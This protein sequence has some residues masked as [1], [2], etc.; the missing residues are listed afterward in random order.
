MNEL[1]WQSQFVQALGWT[2]IEFVPQGVLIGLAYAAL[3]L[4][5]RDASAQVRLFA[6]QLSLLA[7]A[8]APLCTLAGHLMAGSTTAV[9]AVGDVAM[10]VSALIR[11]SA[12]VAA[13]QAAPWLQPL[14]A[15]WAAGVLVLGMRAMIQWLGL[16]WVK[17]NARPMDAQWQARLRVLCQRMGVSGGVR[18]VE[19]AW[20]EVPLVIGWLKPVIVIPMGLCLRMP[21]EQLELVIVHELAHL[22][23]FDHVVNLLQVVLETVL[24]YHPVVHWIS[25]CVREDR[26][27]C[28]DDLV[29]RSGGDRRTYARALLALEE[30]R[31]PPT[32]L[33]LAASGGVLLQR[34]ERVVLDTPQAGRPPLALL[35]AVAM[36]FV[37]L[38]QWLLPDDSRAAFPRR[39]LELAMTP[40]LWQVP[41]ASLPAGAVADIVSAPA[42]LSLDFSAPA[43]ALPA[44][45]TE[46]AGT[47]V[48]DMDAAGAVGL[49][50][51]WRVAPA[52]PA[53]DAAAL[54][55]AAPAAMTH[56]APAD[57]LPDP[58]E[59]IETAPGARPTLIS[60]AQPKYPAHALATGR[61]GHVVA[62][63]LVGADGSV[64]G[65]A[66]ESGEADDAFADSVRRA[67]SRWRF[68]ATGR[69]IMIRQEF[70]FR[71]DDVD[72]GPDAERCVRQI[73]SRLCRRAP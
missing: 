30:A 4:G 32:R 49:P 21:A 41:R 2:L 64:S 45:G 42:R 48:A 37:V 10:P 34:V 19:S 24:F 29:T 1:W 44:S 62:S 7:L 57:A 61:E 39:A 71:V 13:A 47:D 20:A 27:Q 66:I 28:C 22:R 18:L 15:A 70:D 51:S 68:A 60:G 63:F 72:A 5:W 12:P 6:G 36:A 11:E 25:R 65:L 35:L 23:R 69:E 52:A 31:V 67:V 46:G 58:S 59:S 14:V 43:V 33:A 9:G 3:R 8:L 55:T 17:R 54:A 50:E 38:V 26:E 53:A 73:G 40:V 56:A 16:Q